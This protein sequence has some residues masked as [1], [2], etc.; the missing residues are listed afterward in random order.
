MGKEKPSSDTAKPESKDALQN[1]TMK[2][3]GN[4]KLSKSLEHPAFEAETSSCGKADIISGI[5]VNSLPKSKDGN[6]SSD[7]LLHEPKHAKQ[8]AKDGKSISVTR[9]EAKLLSPGYAS[10]VADTKFEAASSPSPSSDLD[11]D[12]LVIRDSPDD[13]DKTDQEDSN[14]PSSDADER[15][16]EKTLDGENTDRNLIDCEPPPEGNLIS[17]SVDSDMTEKA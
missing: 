4:E 10:F 11:E 1:P 2:G 8:D 13:E 3:T 12:R 5:E 7:V 17:K 15:V 14:V 16:A 6:T 9:P